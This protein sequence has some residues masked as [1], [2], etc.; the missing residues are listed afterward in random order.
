MTEYTGWGMD[1]HIFVSHS[2]HV[3][4]TEDFVMMLFHNLICIQVF[5]I[6]IPVSKIVKILLHLPP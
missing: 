1:S 2:D 4:L 6:G 3:A 5:G